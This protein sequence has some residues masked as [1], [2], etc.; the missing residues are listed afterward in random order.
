MDHGAS[1]GP[2]GRRNPKMSPSQ[3]NVCTAVLTYKCRI[4]LYDSNFFLPAPL[5]MRVPPTLLPVIQNLLTLA[6]IGISLLVYLDPWHL[7]PLVK[8]TL[9]TNGTST[10]TS[11]LIGAFG[12]ISL[13][14]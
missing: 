10:N 1:L 9:K 5:K 4:P 2:V 3:Q 12:M 8:V 14:F 6:T 7:A 13:F 11:V